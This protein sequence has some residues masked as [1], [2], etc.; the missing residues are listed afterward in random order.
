MLSTNPGIFNQ[1][2][3]FRQIIQPS[4]AILKNG[5]APDYPEKVSINLCV[6]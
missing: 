6:W 1:A 4:E 3:I 2:L 5:T